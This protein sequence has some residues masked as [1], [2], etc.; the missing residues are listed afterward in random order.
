MLSRDREKNKKNPIMIW[1][2]TE[3]FHDSFL[4]TFYTV[5]AHANL[6]TLLPCARKIAGLHGNA[7]KI[8]KT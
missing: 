3:L 1:Q 5:L 4:Y 8:T 2:L 7:E 6:W